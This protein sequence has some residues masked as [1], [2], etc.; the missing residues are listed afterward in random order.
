MIETKFLLLLKLCSYNWVSLLG[1]LFVNELIRK[2][3]TLLIKATSRLKN[4]YVE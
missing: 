2:E 1:Y 3:I 4:T